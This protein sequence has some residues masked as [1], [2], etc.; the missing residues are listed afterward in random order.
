MKNRTDLLSDEDGRRTNKNKTLK[1]DNFSYS[2]IAL[3]NFREIVGDFRVNRSIYITRTLTRLCFSVVCKQ[4]I[5]GRLNG[6][7]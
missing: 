3:R 5:K 7:I 1:L 6:L 2:D 4:N